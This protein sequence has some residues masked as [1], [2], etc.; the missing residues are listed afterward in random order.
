MTKTNVRTIAFYLPQYHPI[1]ENDEWWGKGFT[2]WT[3]VTKAKPLFKGHYQP[4]I[5]A[6]LSFYDL[7]L[8]ETR[9]AQ[10]EL[11]KEYGIY[12][13][14]YYHYWFSGRHLL[15]RPFNEVLAS[16]KPDL[17]FC[18]CWA[19]EN[20]TRTW[21]GLDNHVLIDQKYGPEDDRQHLRWLAKAFRDERYIRIDGKPLFLVYRVSKIPNP[22][23]TTSIWRE[24]AQKLGIGEIY[25]ATVESLPDDRIDPTR[26]GFDAAVEFQPDWLHL[27]SLPNRIYG[28]NYVYDYASMVEVMLRKKKPPY[29]RFPC[30]TP[31]W[32]NSPRRRK[33]AI[34]LRDSTP[35]LYQRWLE[36]LIEDFTLSKP[37]ENLVFINSWNEWGEGAHLEPCQRWGQAYLEATR[38]ALQNSQPS[39]LQSHSI[40]VKPDKKVSLA[41]RVSVCIPTYNGGRYIGEA[42]RSV[43]NQTLTDFDLIIVDD[44]SED[45]TEAVIKSFRDNRI[46]Y[47]KNPIRLGMIGN[48]NKCLEL[49]NREYVCIF[50]QDDV[51]MH[52]NLAEKVKILEENPTVGMVHSNVFQTGP[53]GEVISKWWYLKPHPDQNGLQKG[54]EYFETLLLGVNLVCC[55]SAVVRRECFDKLGGFDR[56]LPFTTDWE[57]WMR[58]AL[59]YDIAYLTEPLVKYRRHTENETLNFLGVKELEHAFRAKTSILRKYP[60]RIP[61]AQAL[62][63]KV[64]EIHKRQALEQASHLISQQQ[65]SA[66]QQ[67][68]T[69]ALGIHGTSIGCSSGGECVDWFL[70]LIHKMWRQD[71]QAGLPEQH[72]QFSAEKSRQ[73]LDYQPKYR[74]IVDGLKGRNIAMEIPTK[75]L[76][77]ALC[78]KIAAKPGFRW[79]RSF[80]RLGEKILR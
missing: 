43:L 23:H 50:H 4:H 61:E 30:V 38:K 53:A 65:Y 36:R 37:E 2:E 20:W 70:E 32:D 49:S 34:V 16:G 17:P 79:L 42:I 29:K 40:S 51:M 27:R 8:P 74:Q 13:F 11:A 5:P 75:K 71:P 25:L 68:L 76:I 56:G 46:R 35:E 15:E 52:E 78:Y 54:L 47:F 69:L 62:K 9:E 14:C 73:P 39:L 6:D 44:C 28:D 58:L 31:S 59:F 10:A 64:A 21:D 66:A 33:Q 57:M 3:M 41:P 60:E 45:N 18:L 48:W 55:P 19:N 80:E 12:G 22:Y 77:K 67:Y 72:P 24:E 1:P 7:R 63:S 26:N